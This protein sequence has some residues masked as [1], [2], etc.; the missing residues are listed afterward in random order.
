MGKWSGKDGGSS[1][2]DSEEAR[3]LGSWS[4]GEEVGLEGEMAGLELWR[5]SMTIMEMVAMHGIRCLGEGQRS[6]RTGCLRCMC[7]SRGLR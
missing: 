1:V 7:S 4:R 6:W 2:E 3:H 5:L